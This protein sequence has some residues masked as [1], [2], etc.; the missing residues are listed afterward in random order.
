MAKAAKTK[1]T[2]AKAEKTIIARM[3]SISEKMKEVEPDFGGTSGN[4]PICNMKKAA[5]DIRELARIMEF[6]EMQ[7]FLQKIVIYMSY[8]Q[9][10]L[11]FSLIYG[12]IHQS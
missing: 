9:K 5:A 3:C 6:S 11:I 8:L 12:I 2:A 10:K 7:H 4:M 1:A